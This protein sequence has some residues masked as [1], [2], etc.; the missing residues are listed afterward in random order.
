MPVAFTPGNL[1]NYIAVAKEANS[2]GLSGVDREAFFL[3]RSPNTTVLP[4]E[5]DDIATHIE[6]QRRYILA[7][8]LSRDAKFGPFVKAQ[9]GYSCAICETQLEIIEGAH[10]IPISEE[11]SEDEVWN[12]IALCPNHH[13]LF[14]AN[15]L[16]VKPSL[17]IWI[18]NA[19]IDYF[20]ECGR[21]GGVEIL[22]TPFHGNKIR[23][24]KFFSRDKT[25]QKRM[26]D[27]LVRRADL[28]AIG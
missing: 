16:I 28:A 24:P 3:F 17:K 13:K 1:F 25:A 9:Y 14:D 11:G 18:D 10:I 15:A 19:S 22:L 2:Q 23:E 27:A 4:L 20:R 7:K 5:E 12:G 26:I 21:A 8:R 6:Q